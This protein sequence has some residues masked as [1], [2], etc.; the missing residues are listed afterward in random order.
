M[1]ALG[2]FRYD[3][4]SRLPPRRPAV[5]QAAAPEVTALLR[6]WRGGDQAALERLA[7]VV[8]DELRRIARR[9]QTWRLRELRK[10]R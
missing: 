2:A 4:E 8:Y 5:T 9:H 3:P 6:A 10:D 7:P 1:I